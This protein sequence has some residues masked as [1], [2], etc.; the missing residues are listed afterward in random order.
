[1][2][3][4]RRPASS[5][6]R[7]SAWPC[8]R[9]RLPPNRSSGP[10]P[11]PSA[12]PTSR[13]GS[14]SSARPTSTPAFRSTPMCSRSATTRTRPTGSPRARRSSCPDASA[15]AGEPQTR[16]A[17]L[18]RPLDFAAVTDHAELY[19][20]MQI[21][22][23]SKPGTPGYGSV[24]CRQMRTGQLTPG[25]LNPFGVAAEWSINPILRPNGAGP[26]LPL[27]GRKGVDCDKVRGFGLEGDPGRRR[28][29][30]RPQLGLQLH[31]LRR[32]RVHGPAQVREPAPQRHLPDQGGR[33]QP[34][35]Q[36]HHQWPLPDQA[37]A[38]AARAVPGGEEGLRRA[39]PSRTTPI[40]RA[41]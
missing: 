7:C 29:P 38:E 25:N 41:G 35:Q 37:V 8:L 36:R 32:L 39:A 17:R 14:P 1:M 2:R 11:G 40:W 13:S 31:H 5:S 22:T 15:V 10:N 19:G 18:K 12:T 26:L 20:P 3:R 33:R 9:A 30:L 24:Q 23:R 6:A 21:C 34:D 27:C 28:D 4:W 16:T